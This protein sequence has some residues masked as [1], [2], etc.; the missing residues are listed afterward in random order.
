[1]NWFQSPD[2][3]APV[4]GREFSHRSRRDAGYR[5][6]GRTRDPTGRRNPSR[7]GA[8]SVCGLPRRPAPRPAAGARNHRCRTGG[9]QDSTRCSPTRRSARRSSHSSS[10]VRTAGCCTATSPRLIGRAVSSE[11]GSRRGA[12]RQDP[13][14]DGGRRPQ[15]HGTATRAGRRLIETYAPVHVET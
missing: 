1:M 12:R 2:A 11:R 13:C 4:P 8:E 15:S 5:V 6:L 10:G 3:D 7:R 14:Q 9:R